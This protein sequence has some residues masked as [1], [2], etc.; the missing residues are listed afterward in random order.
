MP[1]MDA[2]D[3][4]DDTVDALVYLFQENWPLLR[5]GSISAQTQG[6]FGGPTHR[7]RHFE[8]LRKLDLTK[9]MTLR[10][11]INLLRACA[12]DESTAASL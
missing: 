2:A 11:A 5:K 4:Y 8:T 3:L 9:Q 12:V 7:R 10:S 1:D 6:D